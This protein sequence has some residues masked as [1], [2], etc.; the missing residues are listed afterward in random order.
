VQA[1][2]DA[3]TSAPLWVLTS[4]AVAAV[5]GEV[6][7]SPVPAQSWAF[8]RVAA[9]EHPDRW[10]GLIDLPTT[11]DAHTA[12]RL[13]AVLAG[14]LG[15]SSGSGGSGED[16]VAIRATGVLGRRLVRAP[17]PSESAPQWKPGGSVLITGGTGGVGGH[18]ARWL[19]KRDAAQIVL[20]SRSGPAASG[21]PALAAEVAAAG[22]DVVVLA[23][24][25]GDRA[26]TA[27]LLAWIDAHGPAVSSI[28]H[29]AGAGIGGPLIDM[30][31]AD[32][33][34]VLQAKAGGAT[35]L[36]ELTADRELDAFVV[37]S[38]GAATWG[39][40]RLSGYAAANGA[41]DALVE[42]RRGRGLSGTSVA[43]GLWGGGGMGEGPAGEMLQRLGVRE[44]EPEPAVAALAG[45]MDAGEDLVAV[46]DIDWS[47]FATIFT[48][49]RPS[50]LL[51]DLPEAQQAIAEATAS[52]DESDQKGSALSQRLE[53]LSRADQ[54]RFLIELVRAEAAAVLGYATSEAVP[55][56]RAFKDLGFDSL[57]AVDLRTR[58][59]TATGLKLPATLVFDYPTPTALAEFIRSKAVNEQSD[60]AVAVAE[61]KLLQAV[62]A[63][64]AWSSEERFD[65]TSRLESIGL[66]LRAGDEGEERGP[67]QE[68]EAATDDE[69]F[70]F[71][72]KELRAAD[73]D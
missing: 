2:D 18:V 39:S 31:P 13:V 41:L 27:G 20:S 73:F 34:T 59:N 22:S 68:L 11:W 50:R 58:L 42:D 61:L 70:D 48:V 65:L 15:G 8:G 44:M 71:V 46:S 29:A 40:A 28:M 57:T 51:A 23:G 9:L 55:P 72:E 30:S 26:Q 45:A 64:A 63:R 24:D 69:M 1:L 6:P 38:S 7:V 60:Y 52:D 17:R 5:E 4:G 14:E 47:R 16:Q 33:T 54:D 62:L 66:A 49:Q 21:V 32:L 35:Y 56:T 36:D 37:F 67:D 25:V 10:G 12:D 53:G 43:W 19:T 3:E